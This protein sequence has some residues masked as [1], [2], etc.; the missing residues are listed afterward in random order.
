MANKKWST[1]LKGDGKVVDSNTLQFT[2]DNVKGV[3]AKRLAAEEDKKN[4]SSSQTECVVEYD[5]EN[6]PTLH[7]KRKNTKDTPF[8]ESKVH[9]KENT[10][11]LMSQ[12]YVLLSIMIATLKKYD[13]KLVTYNFPDEKGVD[14]LLKSGDAV[15][16]GTKTPES[17]LK[18]L[19]E[20]IPYDCA[21]LEVLNS[22]LEQKLMMVYKTKK[23]G[24]SDLQKETDKVK[25]VMKEGI[26]AAAQQ[27]RGENARLHNLERT[28]AEGIKWFNSLNIVE[29]QD[30]FYAYKGR[31]MSLDQHL[32]DNDKYEIYKKYLDKYQAL[33]IKAPKRN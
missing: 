3:D 4:L 20:V 25:R 13:S 8:T 9:L 24:V 23:E 7:V 12:S 18:D 2:Y 32:T 27:A 15:F 21:D 14:K 22:Q 11:I 30:L 31:K 33:D 26:V 6:N 16:L 28:R 5:F 19:K 17:Y 10:S 29:R 1:V